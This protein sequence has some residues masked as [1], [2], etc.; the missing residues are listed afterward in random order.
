MSGGFSEV[1]R[2]AEGEGRALER[3]S[4]EEVKEREVPK[5]EE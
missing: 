2:T 5:K 3:R 1:W 4:H